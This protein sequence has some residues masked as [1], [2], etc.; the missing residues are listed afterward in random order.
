MTLRAIRRSEANETIP[1]DERLD[2]LGEQIVRN[3]FLPVPPPERIFV[4]D[5]GF[6]PIGV[7][8]LKWFVR[9][10]DL[11]PDERVLDLGCGI[12]R[13]EPLRALPLSSPRSR[14]SNL[15]SGRC[16][17]DERGSPALR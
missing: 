16:R 10:G 17:D 4:G 9:L 8:F 15:Q 14:P 6:L 1:D 3:R 5:G 11:K 13:M 2:W 12:G 7:E